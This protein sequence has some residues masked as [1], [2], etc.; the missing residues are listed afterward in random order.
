MYLFSQ[1]SVILKN[2]CA[3]FIFIHALLILIN[4]ESTF[5]LDCAGAMA[6]RDQPHFAMAPV[7]SSKKFN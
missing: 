1:Q 6:K 2:Y 7:Q 4:Q 5:L 3:S